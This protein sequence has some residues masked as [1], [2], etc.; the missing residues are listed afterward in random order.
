MARENKGVM[1]NNLFLS[2]CIQAQ[3]KSWYQQ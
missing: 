3:R 2:V 1:K